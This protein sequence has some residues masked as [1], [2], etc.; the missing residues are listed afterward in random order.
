MKITPSQNNGPLPYDKSK[1]PACLR[2]YRFALGLGHKLPDGRYLCHAWTP[3]EK[4][5][6]PVQSFIFD[7]DAAPGTYETYHLARST[8]YLSANTITSPLDVLHGAALAE[9]LQEMYQDGYAAWN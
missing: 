8:V 6:N 5:K 1:C 7:P 2:S 3:Q 9:K 4:P